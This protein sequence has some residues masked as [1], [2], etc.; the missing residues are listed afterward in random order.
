M[1]RFKLLLVGIGAVWAATG[2]LQA[3]GGD[4]SQPDAGDAS[5]TDAKPKPDVQQQDASG[6]GPQQVTPKGTELTPTDGVQIFG[7]TDDDD[8]IYADGSQS[9]ALYA[10]PSSG[11]TPV[12]IGAP[13]TFA[14][15]LH[16]K[17]VFVWSGLTAKGV[18][19]LSIWQ[20]GGTLTQVETHSAPNGGFAASIDGKHLVYTANSDVNGAN[21][22]I[23]GANADASGK[24][25]LVTGVDIGSGN[26]CTPRLGFISNTTAISST[27]TVTPPDG[28]TPSAT[29]SSYVLAP[30]GD[31]GTTWTPAQIVASAL[32]FWSTDAAGDKVL[33][34]TTA[35]LQVCTFP[36]PVCVPGEAKNIE[37]NLFTFG[38][39][40]QAGSSIIYSTSAGDLRTATSALPAVGSVVQAANVN[41]VRAISPDDNYI[42][43]TKTFDTQQFGG[44]LYLTSTAG[45]AAAPVTLDSTQT[46]A[47]FGVSAADDFSANSAYVVWV[48]NLNTTQGIGD[49]MA[50]PVAGGTPKSYA[51][52]EWQNVTATGTKVVYNNNCSGCSGT[53]GTG[54]AYADIHSVDLATSTDSP[55]QVGADVPLV[56]GGNSLFL[57]HDKTKVIYSYSQNTA[58]TGVP[59][60]GGNGLYSIAIP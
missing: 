25:P 41:F 23:V 16:H 4:N 11:G 59:A 15:G 6:D 44:D 39:M 51:S 8:V 14:V 5:A 21:G 12:K 54:N 1:T 26:N 55:L 48:A 31:A 53:G 49:L 20:H 30:G 13:A 43:F 40:N 10:V 46:G 3:C 35:G 36:T 18:G 24:T 57:S 42:M 34:A 45:G 50:V 56:A 58:S 9:N 32:N 38:Y 33:V 29:V 60:A 52:G 27:C 7:V 22:D 19:I 47:L 28:G 37:N 17:T 2:A